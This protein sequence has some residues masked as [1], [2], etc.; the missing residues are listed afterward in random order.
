MDKAK[1]KIGFIGVGGMGQC[2]HLKNYA[3]LGDECTVVALAELREDVGKKVA[4]KYGIPKIYTTAADL[5]KNEK[6]DGLVASQPFSRHGIMLG[7]LAKAGV[8]VFIE[9]PLAASMQVAENILK[10][11]GKAKVKVMV[12]YHKRSDPATAYAKQVIDELKRTNELGRMK[13]VRITM[14]A[15]DWIAAGFSDLIKG[16]GKGPALDFDPPAADMDEPTYKKYTSFV[17]YYIHQVNLMRHL[18]GET[19]ELLYADPGDVIIAGRSKS[20]VT[21][22]IE[23]SPYVTSIEWEES[24]LVAFEKG[25]V[26]IDLPAPLASNRPGKVEVLKD[27]GK[28]ATPLVTSPHL[29]WEHAMKAQARNFIAFVRGERPAPCEAAEAYEDLKIARQYIKLFLGK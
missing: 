21:C 25:Y 12:G 17:N 19:Y 2:A 9:K 8:P 4:A 22:V 27:P 24:A 7:E 26:K 1:T 20:G 10:Q 29:P 6:V 11:I 13:F 5:L 18:L 28:G 23:M 15:G 3:Q 16:E 14:P